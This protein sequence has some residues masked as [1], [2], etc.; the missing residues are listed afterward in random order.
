MSAI[1]NV[2]ILGAGMMGSEIALICAMGNY[3]VLLKD[4]NM[5]LARVGYEKA[6]ASLEKWMAKARS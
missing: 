4:M 1:K 3:S 2:G 5:A 6:K